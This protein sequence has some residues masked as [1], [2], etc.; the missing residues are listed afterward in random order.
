[1][2]NM[3]CAWKIETDEL[4]WAFRNS[5]AKARDGLRAWRPALFVQFD[6]NVPGAHA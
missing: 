5:H 2:K 6:T 4:P 1:M 3:P